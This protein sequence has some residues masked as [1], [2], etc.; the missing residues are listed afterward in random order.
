MHCPAKIKAFSSEHTEF[1][2]IM[3]I[4]SATVMFFIVSGNMVLDAKLQTSK[5]IHSNIMFCQ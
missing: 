3:F 1:L 2:Q 5:N 4:P